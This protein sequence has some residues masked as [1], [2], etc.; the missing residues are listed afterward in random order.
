MFTLGFDVAKDKLD[1]ALI[2]RSG[3]LKDRYVEKNSPKA[4]TELLKTVRMKHPKVRCGCEATGH[5]HVA[6]VRA[7][8]SLGIEVRILNPL[9]TKQ[10]T[11]ATIRGRKTD[12]DDALSIARLILRDEGRSAN[13]SDI[14]L[15]KLYVRLA[16]K[17]AQQR[18]ALDLQM[19]FLEALE[20]EDVT[21]I[22]ERFIPA[23]AALDKLSLELRAH[24]AA[25]V[26]QRN[27]ELLQSIVGIGP[28]IAVSILA[29]I[30][31]ISRFPSSKQL[32]AFAGFDPKQKQSGTSLNRTGRLTKRG[33]PELRRVLFLAATSARRYDTELKEYYQKKRNEGKRYTPAV[34]AVTQK[35][36][37]RVYAVLTR[38]TP[39]VTK[40]T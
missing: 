34:I 26:N 5:Y 25:N 4:I 9:M 17:V 24:A 2:N 1:V 6:L 22:R 13:L 18:Q 15:P 23:I 40:S 20:T 10:Y 27:Y 12:S 36:T 7:C 39:Y 30:G 16:T 8:L 11:R 38:Q 29:E 14:A 3:Q 32:V 28:H 31:D 21:P 19:Q 33:S 37:N 35:L